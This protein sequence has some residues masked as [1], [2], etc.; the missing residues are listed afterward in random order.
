ML[1]ESR[2]TT[3]RLRLNFKLKHK[4]WCLHQ[5]FSMADALAEPRALFVRPSLFTGIAGWLLL[6]V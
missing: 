4:S 6:L 3:G 2:S 5:N 1:S